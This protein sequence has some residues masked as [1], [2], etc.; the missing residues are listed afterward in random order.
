MGTVLVLL[1]TSVI[2]HSA[3]PDAGWARTVGVAVQGLALLATL[4]ISNETPRLFRLAS[5]LVPL[6]RRPRTPLPS[7]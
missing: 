3:A 5:V 7:R 4:R 2:W 1:A 6:L